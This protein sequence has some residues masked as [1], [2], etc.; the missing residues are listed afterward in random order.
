MN[1]LAKQI[2]AETTLED[3]Q[4][5]ANL[6]LETSSAIVTARPSSSEISASHADLRTLAI[7]RLVGE[8]QVKHQTVPWSCVLKIIDTA[9]HG[10][11]ADV[12]GWIDPFRELAVYERELFRDGESGFRPA[13]CYQIT[14]REQGILILWLEDLTE[15]ES[16]PF[17][18]DQLH[19]LTT[20][21]G[22]FNGFHSTQQLDDSLD[23]S[24]DSF[25]IRW[26]GGRNTEGIDWV[27]E[28][29]DVPEIERIFRHSTIES[30]RYINDLLDQLNESSQALRRGLAFGDCNVGN[31]FLLDDQ[32]VAIDWATLTFDPIG[33]D[34][35]CLIGSAMFTKNLSDVLES[36]TELLDSYIDGLRSGGWG[37]DESH[38]RRAFFGQFGTYLLAVV[39]TIPHVFDPASEQIDH[40]RDFVEKRFQTP[41][42][43][44]PELV[45]PVVE[46]YPRYAA[47]IE[48]L[49]GG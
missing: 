33:V 38:I 44:V 5:V 41:F 42:D 13:T 15:A 36:E 45:A 49:I 8:A 46:S 27:E 40:L 23:T 37:G 32:T 17:S 28:H 4:S 7:A 24:T 19:E 34:A 10:G 1:H 48:K 9:A 22:E 2:I 21:L 26:K 14:H 47:E 35:G 20:D 6:V 16:A 31:L 43:E 18:V 11:I 25:L 3:F 12:G 39:A 29:F 30:V